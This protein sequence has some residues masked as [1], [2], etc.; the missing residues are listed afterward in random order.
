MRPKLILPVPALRDPQRDTVH[1]AQRV[2]RTYPI[3]NPLA[4]SPRPLRLIATMTA[5]DTQLAP[6][7]APPQAPGL[8][9]DRLRLAA[10]ARCQLGG[11]RRESRPAQRRCQVPGIGGGGGLTH[12]RETRFTAI[13]SRVN[14][15]LTGGRRCP[16]PR[17]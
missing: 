3:S 15:S 16:R 8:S 5:A 1:L 2:A 17:G 13:S 12:G 4:Q 11:V 10:A 9:P 7:R 6:P 14:F